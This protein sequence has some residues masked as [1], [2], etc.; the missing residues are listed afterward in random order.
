VQ[1]DNAQKAA[2]RAA[3]NERNIR[4]NL[5][6][7][8]TAAAGT[9]ERQ[10]ILNEPS[11]FWID[12]KTGDV[13]TKPAANMRL[14]INEKFEDRFWNPTVGGL[15]SY[16]D[17]RTAGA[18]VDRAKSQTQL[19]A[20]RQSLM[21]ARI[22]TI[23]AK[24]DGLKSALDGLR[25]AQLAKDPNAEKYYQQEVVRLLGMESKPEEYNWMLSH[26]PQVMTSAWAWFESVTGKGAEKNIPPHPASAA[27]PAPKVEKPVKAG[28]FG[29][30]DKELDDL[31]KQYEK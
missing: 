20:T 16:N 15:K 10:A 22:K 14:D 11:D 18:R 2:D 8:E 24:N 3:A 26:L 28:G 23:G 19:D 31:L 12:N 25:K 21:E 6:R 5:T 29:E 13:L 7:I 27:P 17:A 9:K 30:V 4:D 1:N